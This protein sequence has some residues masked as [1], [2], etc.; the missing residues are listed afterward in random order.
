MVEQFG[1]VREFFAHLTRIDEGIMLLLVASRCPVCGGPLHRSDYERKPRG[2]LL[3]P[4]GEECVTR[5][6]L[7][8]GREGCR[9]RATP[10]SLRFLGRRVYLGAVVLVASMFAR[11][12]MSAAEHREVT[13]VPTRTTRR[14]LGWWCDAFARTDV[15]TAVCAQLIGVAVEELPASIVLR[16]EGSPTEQVRAMLAL[17]AP[18][19]TGSVLDGARFLRGAP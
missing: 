12:R 5:F 16:L 13:G 7:C 10:P 15:F 19:T 8:C 1:L 18:L 4:A 2:A 11:M 14:W 6:S 9:K 3:A 17:L